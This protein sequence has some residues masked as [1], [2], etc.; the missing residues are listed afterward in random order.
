[1]IDARIDGGGKMLL[2]ARGFIEGAADLLTQLG[3]QLC[4]RGRFREPAPPVHARVRKIGKPS[5][6]E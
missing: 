4:V 1:M 5:F 2:V 3:G 6:S